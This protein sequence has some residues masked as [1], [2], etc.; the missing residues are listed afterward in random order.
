MPNGFSQ[1]GSALI[2]S[3][4]ASTGE[5]TL[6][7]NVDISACATVATRGSVDTSVPFAPTTVEI[8]SG[9]AP[10]TVGIEERSLLFFGGAV[11]DEAFHAA[12]ICN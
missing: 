5:Y 7:T 9:P 10:Y 12:I 2:S 11:A 3:F 4:R 8:V 1:R 6:V